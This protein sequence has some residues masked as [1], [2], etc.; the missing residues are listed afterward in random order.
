MDCQRTAKE[1]PVNVRCVGTL[2][3]GHALYTRAM[4]IL[5]VS[6]MGAGGWGVQPDGGA[7]RDGRSRD[8]GISA[9]LRPLSP[10]HPTPHLP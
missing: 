8:D 2:H 9:P 6:H 10:P 7:P 5:R 1:L 4:Y 3:G